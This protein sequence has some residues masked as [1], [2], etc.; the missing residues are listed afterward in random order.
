MKSSAIKLLFITSMLLLVGCAPHATSAEAADI[1][2]INGVLNNEAGIDK[3]LADGK[4][5]SYAVTAG[6]S[7]DARHYVATW[8]G[9][10]W[11]ISPTNH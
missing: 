3:V 6:T 8:S 9:T 10:K 11:T 1:K 5:A 2:S 4:P 7:S